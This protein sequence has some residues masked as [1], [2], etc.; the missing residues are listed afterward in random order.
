MDDLIFE[1]YQRMA[2]LLAETVI[3]I[4][5]VFYGDFE[6]VMDKKETCLLIANHQTASEL[7]PCRRVLAIQ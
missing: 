2:L 4:E 6:K 7:T 5:V 3:G 1:F